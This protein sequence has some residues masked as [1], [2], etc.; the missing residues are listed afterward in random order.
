MKNYTVRKEYTNVR[1]Y[2]NNIIKKDNYELDGVHVYKKHKKFIFSYK[3]E[4][5]DF[6]GLV[7]S[8]G[9][10]YKFSVKDKQFLD[11]IQPICAEYGKLTNDYC[12]FIYELVVFNKIK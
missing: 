8:L 3:E 4:I 12:T 7:Y 11:Y 2:L 9:N 5:G 1:D 10:Q 6:Y